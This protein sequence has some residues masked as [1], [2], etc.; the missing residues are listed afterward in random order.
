MDRQIEREREKKRG[1]KG[2]KGQTRVERERQMK[3]QKIG[4]EMKKSERNEN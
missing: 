1:G 3:K 4:R 2:R